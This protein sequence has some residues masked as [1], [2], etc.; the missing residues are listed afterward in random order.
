MK[1]FISLI[2]AILSMLFLASCTPSDAPKATQEDT[3]STIDTNNTTES[4]NTQDPTIVP[5]TPKNEN[6]TPSE[7]QIYSDLENSL[8]S[9]N[10]S[11][12]IDSTQIIKSLTGEGTYSVTLAVTAKSQYADWEY[13]AEMLYTK[14]DQGWMNDS[15][16]WNN[17][18][19]NPTRFPD[20]QTM[21]D[22]AKTYLPV[23]AGYSDYWIK[24]YMSDIID[25]TIDY[26]FNFELQ[27]FALHFCWD[28]YELSCFSKEL[29]QLTSVWQYDPTQDNWILATEYV[30]SE[31]QGRFPKES[32]DLNGSWTV[33]DTTFSFSNFT[34]DK[35]DFSAQGC[36]E[37]WQTFRRTD[38][39]NSP[40]LPNPTFGDI[41]YINDSGNYIIVAFMGDTAVFYYYNGEY[42]YNGIPSYTGCWPITE[43]MYA[44][45]S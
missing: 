10:G 39:W 40:V 31:S 25:P 8:A 26:R 20:V 37:D 21:T 28:T 45:Q 13:E 19:Y 42:F 9:K 24:T 4:Q 29:Y 5:T 35:F 22:H 33:Y 23:H 41:A 17:E 36:I 2:A 44:A 12:S 30:S 43:E 14:Y 16:E 1:Q 11:F 38:D 15:I 32:I 27:T 7:A 6:A 18:S 3:I 34:W